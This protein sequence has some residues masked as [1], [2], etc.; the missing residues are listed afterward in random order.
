M[1]GPEKASQR[2]ELFESSVIQK[3]PFNVR[4]WGA[5]E[6]VGGIA[7]NYQSSEALE[8]K[9]KEKLLFFWDY[10]SPRRRDEE[11]IGRVKRGVSSRL[12]SLGKLCLFMR[13]M[14]LRC[15]FYNVVD[16]KSPFCC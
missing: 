16:T 15:C 7:V 6:N 14:F 11:K 4:T 5:E 10:S 1:G 13:S 9:E 3:R 12:S 8:G 2:G